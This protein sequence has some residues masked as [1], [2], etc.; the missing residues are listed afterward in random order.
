MMIRFLTSIRGSRATLLCSC[1]KRLRRGLLHAPRSR[2]S[3]AAGDGTIHRSEGG[4]TST[5]AA[6][7][8]PPVLLLLWAAADRDPLPTG[9][10]LPT[11]RRFILRT[12]FRCPH[13]APPDPAVGRHPREVPLHLPPSTCHPMLASAS[14][15]QQPKSG[16]GGSPLRSCWAGATTTRATLQQQSPPQEDHPHLHTPPPSTTAPRQSGGV[17]G[18]RGAPTAMWRI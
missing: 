5:T 2:S 10:R 6:T 4:T 15:Q 1:R 17:G 3:H 8:R 18:R 13:R 14:T 7:P 9:A 11:L 16:L 12:K